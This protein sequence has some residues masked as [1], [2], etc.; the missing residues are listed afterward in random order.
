VVTCRCPHTAA[1][2]AA[3]VC[4]S[5][6]WMLQ[7]RAVAVQCVWRYALAR[8]LVAALVYCAGARQSCYKLRESLQ[9]T[10]SYDLGTRVW[11]D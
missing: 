8:R 9:S 11:E 2:A 4:R 1:A 3:A 6:H 10:Q 5:I 7:M